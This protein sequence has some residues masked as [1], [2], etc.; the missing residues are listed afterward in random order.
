MPQSKQYVIYE[1]QAERELIKWKRKVTRKPSLTS[2]L[3]KSA[4]TR[5]NKIIPE[6][7]HQAITVTI[8]QMVRGV[9]FGAGYTAPN[10]DPYLS[11][12]QREDLVRKRTIFTTSA[13]AEGVN[14][15]GDCSGTAIFHPTWNQLNC[16]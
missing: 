9:L 8:K 16:N 6:R 5:I 14:G 13:A 2:Q 10:V 7:V 15:N 3:A 4:Q 11:L 12:E 1:E